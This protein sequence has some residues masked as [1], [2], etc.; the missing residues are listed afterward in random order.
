M[1]T[2]NSARRALR[3][4]LFLL[5]VA[6]A[7]VCGIAARED[8]VARQNATQWESD[9][10]LHDLSFKIFAAGSASFLLA[11]CAALY[12]LRPRAGSRNGSKQAAA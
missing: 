3:A 9:G 11:G 6:G 7:L 12:W 1:L 10:E 5:G 4:V 8:W 2:P